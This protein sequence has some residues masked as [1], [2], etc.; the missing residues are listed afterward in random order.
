[1][2]L[3]QMAWVCDLPGRQYLMNVESGRT[4]PSLRVLTNI[5]GVFKEN[6]IDLVSVPEQSLYE[7]LL[8]LVRLLSRKAIERLIEQAEP[9]PTNR[10]S[11]S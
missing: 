4:R 6:L 5:A 8:A 2:S 10:T 1:M 11:S 7:R 3:A 9:L